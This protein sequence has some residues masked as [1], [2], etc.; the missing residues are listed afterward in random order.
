MKSYVCFAVAFVTLVCFETSYAE[1]LKDFSANAEVSVLNKYVTI[2]GSTCEPDAVVQPSLTISHSSGLYANIWNST[3]FEGYEGD[4][5]DYY[6]GWA[7]DVVGFNADISVGY[8]DL[9]DLFSGRSGN[10]WT[11]IGRLG[12][13]FNIENFLSVEPFV[14]IEGD[15]AERDTDLGGGVLY[16]GGMRIEKLLRPF[17]S[18][19]C[20]PRVTYTEG[21]YSSEPTTTGQYEMGIDW[22]CWRALTIT[23]TAMISIPTDKV[24][25]ET[26]FVFGGAISYGFN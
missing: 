21:V 2:S 16:T 20:E 1:G 17:L 25:R 5:I 8:Y 22:N 26:E 11:V 23:P 3:G 19:W 7:G 12:K 24:D 15:I 18:M 6:L 10:F 13:T 14:R 4:E 9:R